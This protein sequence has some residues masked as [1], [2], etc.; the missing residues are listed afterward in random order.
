MNNSYSKWRKASK[1]A[2]A[3]EQVMNIM[4]NWLCNDLN[5]SAYVCVCIWR[6]TH[7]W[8]N[9]CQIISVVVRLL[10][11]LTTKITFTVKSFT[12]MRNK[13]EE[14]WRKR[15][16]KEEEDYE[17]KRIDTHTHSLRPSQ[18]KSNWLFKRI[19][20]LRSFFFAFVCF[21]IPSVSTCT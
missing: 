8:S 18:T 21:E 5:V 16:S 1:Q 12:S 20:L 3:Y 17:E 19:C 10:L 9:N 2:H 6:H 11:P 15:N 7:S 13:R 4:S 14:K